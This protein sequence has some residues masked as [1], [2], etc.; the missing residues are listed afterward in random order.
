MF[1]TNQ[2]INELVMIVYSPKDGNSIK[3]NALEN[4]KSTSNTVY[5]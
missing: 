1:V 3:M 5:M 2:K 4:M